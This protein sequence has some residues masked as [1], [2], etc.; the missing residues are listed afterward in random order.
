MSE[1]RTT[2]Q[3]IGWDIQETDTPRGTRYRYRCNRCGHK[4]RWHVNGNDAN[5]D[6]HLYAKHGEGE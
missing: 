4:G 1:I 6:D 3:G 2:S 5:G